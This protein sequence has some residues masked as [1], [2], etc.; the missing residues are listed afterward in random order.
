MCYK[1]PHRNSAAFRIGLGTYLIV[2]SQCAYSQ[3]IYRNGAGARSVG[4]AGADTAL[5]DD[6]LSIMHSNPGGLGYETN[7]TVTLGGVAGMV[8]GKFSNRVN[9][10]GGLNSDP[11]AFP[12]GALTTAIP[13]FPIKLG[14]RS[15]PR[16]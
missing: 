10:A 6:P 12:E 7:T 8:D 1:R 16:L 9:K 14:F 3:G 5:G 13:G 2:C 4:L 15:F 11:G